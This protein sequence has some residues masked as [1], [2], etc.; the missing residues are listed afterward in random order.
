M[1]NSV[2]VIGAGNG[3]TAIAAHILSMGGSVKLCDLFPQYL[4]EIMT[5]GYI[6]LTYQDKVT[7]VTPTLV[8]TNVED[9]IKGVKLIMVVTPAFTHRMIAEAC[10]KYLE[11]GQVIVLNP[12]R[13]AGAIEFLNT[14]RELGC[15][16]EVIV[17]ESQTLI[18]S[19]RKTDGN[20]VSIYEVKKSVDISCI[21]SK[22]INMVIEALSPYYTQFEP[23]PNI[24][25]TSFANIGSMFHPAPILLNIGRIENDTKGFKY[26][27]EG[28]SPSVAKMIEIIDRERLGVAKAYNVDII[29]AKDWLLKSYDTYGDTLHE[30][31]IN[32]KGY[33]DILAPTDIQVR[34]ITED[35]P[36]GLVPISELGNAIDVHTPNIDAIIQIS[37]SIYKMDFRETGRSLKNLGIM[38]MKGEEIIE[39]FKTGVKYKL[40]RSS[41]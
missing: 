1:N 24:A 16:K 27:W 11:D 18:Y 6:N 7:K 36:T 41:I 2:A 20:S 39:Y 9:A 5:S 3:G 28:I 4:K 38:G 33:E 37:S 29:S 32:N 14:I 25:W 10:S 21:P 40:E 31:I 13:T 17:A 12:G 34:Y 35:V 19:C 22:K 8:T 23:V 15:K 30:R 26:Y